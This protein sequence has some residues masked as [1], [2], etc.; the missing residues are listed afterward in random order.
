MLPPELT[1]ARKR[2]GKLTLS[3]LSAA[4]RARALEVA[5]KLLTVTRQ[6]IGCEREQVEASWAGVEASAHVAAKERKLLAG[7][8]HLVEARSE[9]SAPASAEPEQ[10]RRR[11]FELAALRRSQLG[12]GEL[13]RREDVL[14]EVAGELG[15]TGEALEQALYADLRSAQKLASCS[16]PNAAALVA[17]YELTQVQ[18]VL[19]R[20]VRI[21]AEVRAKSPD[22]YR[23]LFRK[24]KFRQLLFR[25]EPLSGGGYRL[26]IDGPLSLF[27]ATTKYGLE[28]ALSLPALLSCGQLKLKAELRWGK[29]REKLTFEQTYAQLAEVAPLGGVRSEVA[30]LLEGLQAQAGWQ[31]QLSERLLDLTERGGGVLVPDLELSRAAGKARTTQRVLVEILGFWS[32]DAVFRRIEAAEQGLAERVL[33]VV[34]SRLR[35]SEALLD[36]VQA[37]SLYV[38]KGKINAA[39]L[40]RHA[41]A[42]L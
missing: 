26:D 9:F 35:V 6:S 24:L 42:L 27:G 32:R 38:Y 5:E 31:A 41:E 8:T 18:S 36:D 29:R 20:A 12:D 11:V 37:A 23:E 1:R 30:E 22:A 17:D 21:E 10:V 28:L 19:L 3:A 13:F 39:A 40:L 16:V 33:F 34:S 14:G 4:E 15:L 7:L 25:I 2:E